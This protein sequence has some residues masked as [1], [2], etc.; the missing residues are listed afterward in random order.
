MNGLYYLAEANLY[1]GVFYLAYCLFLNRNT[2]YQLSR[3]YLI[4]SCVVAFILPLVQ[5]SA[6]RSVKT[7]E[8]VYAIRPLKPAEQVNTFGPVK[9]VMAPVVNVTEQYHAPTIGAPSATSVIERHFTWQ[10]GL[11]YAYL[12]G[13]AVLLC[14]LFI[15][16]YTL[17]K[18]TRSKQVVNE[19]K[20]RVIYL[21]GTDVAFSFFNYLFIGT[22]THGANTIIR[23]EMVHIRQKH[24]ADIILLE[25][26]K[27][28][29]WFN[30]F[31]Y[32]LQNSLRSVHEYIADEQTAA[33]ESDALSYASFLLNN[34]YGVGGSSITHSF[35]NY[36]LLKK[37]IIMLNQ[38]RS[39]KLAR[40]KYLVA[41]PICITLLCASSLV[42]SKT[43]AWLDLAPASLKSPGKYAML[44]AKFTTRR[45]LLKITE[46]G[47]TTITDK[48]SIDQPN[49]KVA[50]TAATIT[51]ADSLLLLKDHNIKV[52]VVQDSTKFVTRDG[53]PILPVVNADG[54]HFMDHFLHDNI[55]FTAAKGEKGGL[56]EVGFALDNDRRITNAKVVKSCGAK[57]DALALNGFN[58]Y[59]G[60]VN[61]DPGKHLKIGVY[62]FTD[63][64]SIFKTDSL[65]KDPEFGGELIITNY[66]YP[67]ARTSKGYEYDESGVGF[68]GDNNNTSFAKVVIY[69]KNGEGTWYFESKCTPADLKTLKEK[70]GYTFPSGASSIVQ[71]FNPKDVHSRLGY[72]F[73][74]ASYLDAPYANQFYNYML[75]NIEYPQEAKKAYKG[76]VVVLNF[77]LDN[78]GIISDIAVAKGA[79]NG[80]DEAAVNA[81]K[82]YK[83]AIKDNAGK[84]SLAVLFCVA[85][86]EYRPVVSDDVKKDGYVG[87][88]AIC[89]AKSPFKNGSVKWNH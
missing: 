12:A 48:L 75:D 39:G 89:E 87:E 23:H 4:F 22:D 25:L 66:K 68:P 82:L 71:F 50:Y 52:E 53:R 60:I 3:T 88:L 10:D 80:F 44:N 55:H 69:D 26:L 7:A 61:D 77:N 13:A 45:K 70:Y 27:I 67:T 76:G 57:L 79:G 86:N 85:K 17:F 73:D 74:V 83:Y 40:L 34:A 78:D 2:H 33:H 35:F 37:R 62:F 41:I 42:F 8:P 32:L 72:I 65:G 43:Y 54:Y 64:Y 14:I 58:A 59:K 47:V 81:V 24:S 46:N 30:P 49:K 28:F 18:M 36:N 20:Y 29:N 16:L 21:N 56:V 6:L 11:L 1:L 15:K 9:P 5:V 38:Q 51:K 63:D 31:V 19:G 84:H